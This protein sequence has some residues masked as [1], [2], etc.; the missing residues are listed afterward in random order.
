[1]KQKT[2]TSTFMAIGQNTFSSVIQSDRLTNFGAWYPGNGVY[3]QCSNGY[4]VNAL[5]Y[6]YGVNNGNDKVGITALYMLCNRNNEN[7]LYYPNY[8]LR[9]LATSETST[10][11]MYCPS[12]TRVNGI[13]LKQLA[14]QNSGD[15]MGV[16]NM[17]L[18]CEDG[19]LLY[20]PYTNDSGTWSAWKFCPINS[21]V[22]GLS[23]QWDEVNNYWPN[24]DNTGV[25]NL[26]VNCCLRVDAVRERFFCLFSTE[27]TSP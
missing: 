19:T 16:S 20:K 12:G 6:S 22:C 9:T 10:G 23:V 21:F 24:Y 25:N 2:Y 11:Q 14:N 3:A 26:D 27:P 1:M 8:L 7:L 13:Q 17:K 5:E 4:Y 18:M 15:D